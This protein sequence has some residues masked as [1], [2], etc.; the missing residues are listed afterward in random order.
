M[1]ERPATDPARTG[2]RARAAHGLGRLGARWLIALL[3]LAP[4]LFALSPSARASDIYGYVDEK[5]TAHF[6]AERLDPRYQL[7]FRAGQ[8]FDTTHG[9]LPLG[10][11]GRGLNG[12]GVSPATRTLLDWIESS[13]S[14][15]RA[16]T[17]V[18]AASDRHDIDY[19]LLQA[20]IATES[21]FDPQ[22]VSPK[23]AIGLMQVMPATAERY[24]LQDDQRGTVEAKLLDPRLNIA[25]GARYLR[26]LIAL[27][28]G[29]LELALAAYNAG[30]GA[31]QRAGNQV[32]D[33]PETKNYV[34]TVLQLYAYLKPSAGALAGQPPGRIR[35]ELD[36]AAGAVDH[37]ANVHLG[38]D[39]AVHHHIDHFAAAQAERLP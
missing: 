35:M 36:G 13:P 38:L 27:F 11:G 21:G 6:A 7:F 37:Q 1:L 24:G 10:R 15:R 31:V 2:L 9:L 18:R 22:A 19:E 39:L 25:T 23:G 17:A 28:P 8:S 30:E 12:K 33:Y 26:D 4:T 14:Y 3:V 34:S 16:R 29:R 20:L 5:G 32:P